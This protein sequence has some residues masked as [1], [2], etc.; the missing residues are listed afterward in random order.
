MYRKNQIKNLTNIGFGWSK[1]AIVIVF[2]VQ[3]F[4]GFSQSTLLLYEPFNYQAGSNLSGKGGWVSINDLT[5]LRKKLSEVSD[6]VLVC[7]HRGLHLTTNDANYAAENSMTAIKAAITN[8]VD[9]FECDVRASAD[10]V[11]LLMHD[12]TVNRTTNGSGTVSAMTYANLKKLK[13]KKYGTSIATTDTIPTLEQVLKYCKGKIFITL[14]INSKAPVA[15][16]LAMVNKT[17]MIDEVMFFVSQQSDAAYLLSNGAIPLPSCYST[18]TFNSYIQNNLKPLVF[19]CDN[20]GYTSEW[21]LMKNAG[22]KI[23]DNVY[24]LT[25]TLPTINNWAELDPD[26]ANGVNIVQTDY[27][28]EMIN[29]LKSKNKH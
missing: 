21:M 25:T 18:T 26:L 28:I 29:Y 22:C 20:G 13:L 1:T 5:G 2:L 24:L 27:P 15:D 16:V 19:Q 9:M 12:A 17:G 8:H 7:A 4:M 11:L 23:Y 6:S 14:D 10:G 3:V